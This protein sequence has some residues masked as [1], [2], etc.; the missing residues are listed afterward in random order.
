[1]RTKIMVLAG[2]CLLITAI[3]IISYSTVI[4]RDRALRMAQS[5]TIGLAHAEA[6][7][8]KTAIEP[9]L[10]SV[11]SLAD[12]FS[13]ILDPTVVSSLSRFEINVILKNALKRNPDFLAVYTAWEANQFD[14]MDDEYKNKEFHDQTGRFIP[15]WS[16]NIIT[17]E[18]SCRALTH[19]NSIETDPLFNIRQGDFYLV[20]QETLRSFVSTPN[21]RLIQNQETSVVS[22]TAPIIFNGEFYGIVGIDLQTDFLQTLADRIDLYGKTAKMLLIS[23]HGK[24]AG[25]TGQSEFVGRHIQDVLKTDWKSVQPFVQSGN[26]T[27]YFDHKM[28]KTLIPLHFGNS[29]YHWAVLIQVPEEQI[30]APVTA[31]LMKQVGIGLGMTVIALFSLWFVVNRIVIPIKDLEQ[32][33]Q[34]ITSGILDEKIQT[35]R[36]D[37]VGNLA[38]SLDEMQNTIRKKISQLEENQASLKIAERKYRTIFNEAVEGIFQ[39]SMNGPFIS[40]NTSL[41]SIMGYGSPM[42]LIREVRDISSQFYVKGDQHAELIRKIKARG[43]VSNFEIEL[44][45]KDRT[46]IWASIHAR[47]ARDENGNINYLEGFLEDITERK[48]AEEYIRNSYQ[49]LEHK[50]EERTLDLKE[51]NRKLHKAKDAAHA[52]A[53]AKSAFLAN[54]S[55]EIRTPM[56]GVIAAVDL[57]MGE[58]CSSKVERYLSIIHSSGHSLLG[59]INEILD[60]SKIE[61]GQLQLEFA[62][63]KISDILVRIGDIFA[64]QAVEK[65]IELL[66][67]I[68]PGTPL[69]VIGDSLR[70]Q[71]VIT[72]LVGNA[73]K[74]TPKGGSIRFGVSESQAPDKKSQKLKSTPSVFTFFV[75]DTGVGLKPEFKK[76]LFQPFSQED[77]STTRKHGGTGLGLSISKQL[78]EMMKGQI[79]VDSKIGQG[80]TFSF[81]VQLY[82][83]DPDNEDKY[84]IPGDLK[85]RRVLVVD[86]NVDS[87]NIIKKLLISFGY[88]VE[89][90]NFSREALAMVKERL[91]LGCPFDLITLDWMMPE[92]DGIEICRQIRNDL[93][94]KTPVIIL[95][96]FGRK[97]ECQVTHE[98]GVNSFLTKP[99]NPSKL[100]NAIF[101]VFSK[102]TQETHNFARAKTVNENEILKNRFNDMRIL[103]AEDNLVNQ[104]IIKAVLETVDIHPV[105]VENG[106][107]AVAEVFAHVYDAVLMDIQMPEL[108]GH[109][110]TQKIRQNEKYKNL[111]IIAMTAHAMLGDAEKCMEVGM[112]DYITKP[113]NQKI[114]FKT[115]EKYIG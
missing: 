24:I 13:V 9:A 31:T 110:A 86:D 104:E 71:Q 47:L 18:I 43:K 65:K 105:I 28:L 27:N 78:V 58:Q 64:S 10:Q 82:R 68:E 72:N 112:D 114:V 92:M 53:L 84:I 99:V 88:H 95:T 30:M 41:A 81:T 98:A 40:A 60:F 101:K 102:G 115:L 90:T 49:I 5:N 80:A 25:F 107:E 20:P 59:I 63:F 26:G 38:R 33:A 4:L 50:V 45:R 15:Y 113:I 3:A 62:P 79:W 55:H 85:G 75:C 44:F 67:D 57:A 12:T 8:I 94:L 39:A 108:N 29:E 56:N 35:S 1:M 111:P 77:S 106:K 32:S 100:F 61:A 7:E 52:A 16:R 103:V 51:A 19:Y 54:M 73:I 14:F 2:I 66:I 46:I 83:Q 34:R 76:R 11:L 89:T 42:E 74:F 23:H 48:K 96:E 97:K 109:E 17:G 91:N 93:G 69:A 87:A 21:K 22:C 6:Q 37:E 36:K 70:L